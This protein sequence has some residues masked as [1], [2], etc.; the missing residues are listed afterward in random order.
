MDPITEMAVQLVRELKLAG[1]GMH[2]EETV[3]LAAFAVERFVRLVLLE[4]AKAC[5]QKLVGAVFE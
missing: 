5:D 1:V 2:D 3:T 4:A